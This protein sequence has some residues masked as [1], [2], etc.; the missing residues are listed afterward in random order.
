[1]KKALSLVLAAAL[2]SCLTAGACAETLIYGT[3]HIPFAEFYAAEGVRGEVDAVTSATASKWFSESLAAGSYSAA[4]ENGA[5]GD[6]LGVVYPV[7][8]AQSD[9]DALGEDNYAFTPLEGTPAAYK[10]VT[11][12]DGKASFSAVQGPDTA[13]DAT[14]TLTT[15]TVWGDYQLD[16]D[17]IHNQ[18][19]TSDIGTIYGAL[20]K[21]TDG[22]AYA[23]RQLENI[24]R[25]ELSWSTGF[26]TVEPHNCPL[27]Y[28]DY[29]DIM[30][31]TICAV[32]YIT[33][34]G[35]FTIPAELYVPI[36]FDGGVEVASAPV[37]DGSAAVTLTN[38]PD[39]FS[40]A[41]AVSGPSD[42]DADAERVTFDSALPGSYTLTVVDEGGKYADLSA[43]F[44]LST[45]A[46]PTTYDA[47]QNRLVAAEG[48]DSELAAAFIA[49]ISA[50]TVGEQT[51]A[52]SGRGAVSIITVD[53]E[54][55]LDAAQVSGRGAEAVQ[56]PIFAEDGAYTLTVASTGFD[57]TLTFTV[58]VAR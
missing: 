27:V 17:A 55:D 42:A 51:Y 28:E 6:I 41:F 57:Q 48:A 44:V 20:V 33:E 34:S 36:K 39:D 26:R 56:T 23:M 45:D 35:Y 54:I 3:M 49:N 43:N 46:M 12:E 24:W 8:I 4:H 7:A 53:G 21:T 31:K 18:N 30:G 37:S 22:T 11:V 52:A 9:L 2:L 38:L 40:P 47:A 29:A 1:M 32:T 58:T 13:V 19:G 5:G 10:L 25:D 50:V 16:I 14:V 15:N